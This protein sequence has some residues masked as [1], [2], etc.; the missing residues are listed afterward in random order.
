M[1]DNRREIV[2]IE[3]LAVRPRTAAKMID[4]GT[5]KVYELLKEG[6]LERVPPFD[7]DTRISVRSIKRLLGISE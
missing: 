4:T 5:T 7:S 1:S 2:S 3:P 6:R